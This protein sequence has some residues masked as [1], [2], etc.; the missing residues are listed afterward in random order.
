MI[1]FANSHTKN[2]IQDSI[3]TASPADANASKMLLAGNPD[4][5]GTQQSVSVSL[6]ASKK[7]SV[8]PTNSGIIIS[9]NASADKLNH[10]NQEI[11]A[12][13]GINPPVN[14]LQ[15]VL[16]ETALQTFYG[17]MPTVVASAHQQV[18]ARQ[19]MNGTLLTADANAKKLTTVPITIT[20]M[21]QPVN[22]LPIAL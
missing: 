15:S 4:M 16:M 13:L 22:V 1:V 20:G 17:T 12:T 7:L 19:I 9:A 5:F 18:F 2:A 8:Y 21:P 11:L 14:A 6:P 10:A 3:G